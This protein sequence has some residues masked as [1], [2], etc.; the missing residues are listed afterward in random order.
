MCFDVCITVSCRATFRCCRRLT[1]HS[2]H[3]G[4]NADNTE[5][6]GVPFY[7]L[8]CLE[9]NRHPVSVAIEHVFFGAQCNVLGKWR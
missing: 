5:S 1:K 6:E 2:D 3:F 7:Q 9:Q 4:S 8:C